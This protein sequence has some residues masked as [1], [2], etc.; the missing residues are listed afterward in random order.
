M[1][2]Y[3]LRVG[4]W[5]VELVVDDVYRQVEGPF[6]GVGDDRVEVDLYVQEDDCWGAGVAVIGEFVAINCQ[7]NTMR[8][9]FG[10]LDVAEKVGIV[11]FIFGDGVFGDKEDG[12]GP[13][14][15]FGGGTVFTI[16]LCQVEKNVGDGDFPS[17]FLG[18]VPETVER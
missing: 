3:V 12:I 18:A 17:R 10:D 6:A 11:F 5:V 8:L 1:N 4:H 2:P 14:I 13:F 7:A 16:T 9:S 15:G